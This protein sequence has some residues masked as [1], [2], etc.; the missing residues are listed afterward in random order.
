MLSS[1]AMH[2]RQQ[3]FKQRRKKLKNTQDKTEQKRTQTQEKKPDN[4]K[5]IAN[6][7]FSIWDVITFREIQ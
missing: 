3:Q 7:E 4:H 6:T 5:K 1:S 2:F